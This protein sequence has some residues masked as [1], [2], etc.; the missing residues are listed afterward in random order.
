MGRKSYGFLT[1]FAVRSTLLME[2]VEW[3]TTLNGVMGNIL[4][5]AC[6]RKRQSR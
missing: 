6:L 3:S 5:E 4:S 2:S 1:Y